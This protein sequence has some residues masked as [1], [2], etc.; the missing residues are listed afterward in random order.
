MNCAFCMK[1]LVRNAAGV[2]GRCSACGAP[3]P[4]SPSE[5]YFTLLGSPR[6]FAQDKAR[7]ETA[8]YSL[9]RDLHPDRYS[10]AGSD[11]KWK[12]ISLERMSHVNDAYRTL[13]KK[14]ELRSYLLSMEGFN[15]LEGQ[16]A[17]GAKAKGKIPL[18]LAEEWFEIQELLME[19]PGEARSKVEAF[20]L[21]LNERLEREEKQILDLESKYDQDGSRN[22]LVAIEKLLLEGQYLKSL[23]RDVEKLRDGGKR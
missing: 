5:D 4:L 14:D 21:A 22:A 10:A 17:P 11:P 23:K 12:T 9:S 16:S 19:N 3:Q 6:K 13:T 2:I 7:L 20:A 18:E 15:A 1:D 8:F